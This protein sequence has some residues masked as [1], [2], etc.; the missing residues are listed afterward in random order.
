MNLE[1]YKD[2][3]IKLLF[4]HNNLVNEYSYFIGNKNLFKIVSRT[5]TSKGFF[6]YRKTIKF[7]K[8]KKLILS[9]I[10]NIYTW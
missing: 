3:L 8:Q 10:L 5:K 2:I 1:D 4:H 9:L 6:H 7:F